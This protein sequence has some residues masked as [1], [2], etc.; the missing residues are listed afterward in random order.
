[1]SLGKYKL[2]PQYDTGAHLLEGLKLKIYSTPKV[3]KG[4]GWLLYPLLLRMQGVLRPF[5]QKINSV[6]PYDQN[7]LFLSGF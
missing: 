5:R 3:G 6:L 4:M 7:N 2:K 1:M